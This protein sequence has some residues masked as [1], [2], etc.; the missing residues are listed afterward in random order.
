METF[1]LDEGYLVNVK[2]SEINS[3]DFQDF[4]MEIYKKWKE[5]QI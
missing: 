3:K 2:T 5:K 1:L 4:L